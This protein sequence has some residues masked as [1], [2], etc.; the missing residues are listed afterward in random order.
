MKRTIFAKQ[1]PQQS[2]FTPGRSTLYRI[3]ALRL[4]AERQHEYR[5]PL[6]AAYLDLRAAFTSLDR[7][8]PWNILKT[9]GVPPQLVDIYIHPPTVWSE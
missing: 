1:Q 4:L 6:Y 3:I 7:N 9:I 5:Q 2:G 8:S